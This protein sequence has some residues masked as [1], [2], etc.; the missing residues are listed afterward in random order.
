M[1]NWMGAY[2]ILFWSLCNR[3]ITAILKFISQFI[4]MITAAAKGL[5]DA[6][7]ARKRFFGPSN[8][9]GR[10]GILSQ[11]HPKV[12]FAPLS[13]T[14][15]RSKEKMMK[16][17]NAHDSVDQE[18]PDDTESSIWQLSPQRE[19]TLRLQMYN[20]LL[21]SDAPVA[22]KG[23]AVDNLIQTALQAQVIKVEDLITDEILLRGAE[24]ALREQ[25]PGFSLDAL[26]TYL[27]ETGRSGNAL[28]K[29]F[30]QALF[31][32]KLET[33]DLEVADLHD[34]EMLQIAISY[35]QQKHP[36]LNLTSDI[37]EEMLYGCYAELIQSVIDRVIEQSQEE[38]KAVRHY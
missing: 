33:D 18:V 16:P 8:P 14:L 21:T 7:R 25:V 26:A 23:G 28:K 2:Q 34:P 20:R 4:S 24:A 17:K 3:L 22:I 32:H 11:S 35:L 1:E 27:D 10:E 30:K 6:T 37:A 15:L 29:E 13:L 9:K 31:M 38:E 12:L 5:Y 36:T 19:A